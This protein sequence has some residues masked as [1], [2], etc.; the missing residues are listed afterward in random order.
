MRE[1][2]WVQKGG[3][4]LI[5][6]VNNTRDQYVEGQR[7]MRD[8]NK[9]IATLNML[10]ADC[11]EASNLLRNLKMEKR[12]LT[13]A[14]SDYNKCVGGSSVVFQEKKPW[15]E[16]AF[17]VGVGI[18]F[19]SLEFEDTQ[20]VAFAIGGTTKST[21]MMIGVTLDVISPRVSERL[22]V[23]LAAYYSPI[24][25][26]FDSK[27]QPGHDYLELD[28]DQLKVPIGL[29]YMFKGRRLVPY[30][31]A[32][33]SLTFNVKS[34]ITWYETSQ[35][36]VIDFLQSDIEVKTAELGYWGGVGASFPIGSKLGIQIE[37]RYE[38]TNGVIPADRV[39]LKSPVNNLQTLVALKF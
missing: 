27:Y 7:V 24:T 14:V 20:G 12:S 4:E 6:L 28:L 23:A 34:K 16:L 13:K 9:H 21:A 8:D 1:R 17:G 30:V 2:Y 25:Y 39:Y 38:H 19:S 18:N 22:A 29:K 32:G 10:M 15:A 33:G 5:E 35:S 3:G 37:L 11:P 31:N 26:T 36:P